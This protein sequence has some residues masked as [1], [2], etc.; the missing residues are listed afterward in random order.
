VVASVVTSSP[1]R[2]AQVSREH[3]DA[4]ILTSPAELWER[5]EDH[6]LVVVATPNDAHAALATEAIDRGLPVV[7]DKP[8]A[9]T[10]G[11]AFAQA[12]RFARSDQKQKAG[13]RRPP[14]RSSG[15]RR[16]SAR[17]D[18]GDGSSVRSGGRCG[19]SPHWDRHRRTARNPA[20]IKALA[21]RL[22]APDAR[23]WRISGR[24]PP[25]RREPCFSLDA[26]LLQS[27]TGAA[28]GR[29][30]PFSAG[31][32]ERH[33]RLQGDVGC[34]PPRRRAPEW[35]SV[36]FLPK[37]FGGT[38]GKPLFV[39]AIGVQL[40]LG[41]CPV[42]AVFRAAGSGAGSCA[43]WPGRRWR[44]AMRAGSPGSPAADQGDGREGDFVWSHRGR[45]QLLPRVRGGA[46]GESAL[47]R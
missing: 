40:C 31:R 11:D 8:L 17:A 12:R 36:S 33:S 6:D 30:A 45:R 32:T 24:Q 4:Q 26:L 37:A 10:S 19:S 13:A 20:S 14:P 29:D 39:L 46:H 44:R 38:G 47:A 42:Q 21:G 34:W 35:L 16:G 2:Q 5:A 25:P 22:Q 3:P 1:E 7:V 28:N 15:R 41:W 18:L 43:G 27:R 9:M 23:L